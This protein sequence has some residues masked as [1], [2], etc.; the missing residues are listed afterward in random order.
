M[1]YQFSNASAT[2]ILFSTLVGFKAH[3]A[4]AVA[5]DTVSV[6]EIM[7]SKAFEL[8]SIFQSISKAIQLSV[9]VNCPKTSQGTDIVPSF[10]VSSVLSSSSS[11]S[12]RSGFLLS[13]S[14]RVCNLVSVSLL[15]F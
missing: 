15:I 10:S 1:Y 7:S 9:G 14:P 5:T 3:A 8:M 11:E 13:F 2:V 4:F 12:S 6:S